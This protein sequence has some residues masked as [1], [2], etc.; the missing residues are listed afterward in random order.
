MVRDLDGMGTADK[1]AKK[2]VNKGFARVSEIL[3]LWKPMLP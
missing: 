2:P 3:C 1:N